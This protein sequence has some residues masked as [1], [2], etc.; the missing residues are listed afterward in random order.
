[1]L[2]LLCICCLVLESD[3]CG[4]LYKPQYIETVAKK[5]GSIIAEPFFSNLLPAA[6]DMDAILNEVLA[7]LENLLKFDHYRHNRRAEPTFLYFHP[8][9]RTPPPSL[10]DGHVWPMYLK[11]KNITAQLLAASVSSCFCFL[12]AFFCRMLEGI[13]LCC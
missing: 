13:W 6:L 9:R 12:L 7:W 2:T 8:L 10:F 1:M 3:V 5:K 11:P 4:Y